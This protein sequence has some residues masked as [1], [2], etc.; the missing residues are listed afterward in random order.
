[1][2]Q[3]QSLQI[4]GKGLLQLSK[5]SNYQTTNN[6]PSFSR[7]PSEFRTEIEENYAGWQSCNMFIHDL[8]RTNT[9]VAAEIPKKDFWNFIELCRVFAKNMPTA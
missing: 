3:K 5:L 7:F 1:M 8:L 6:F 9:N 4:S 2:K